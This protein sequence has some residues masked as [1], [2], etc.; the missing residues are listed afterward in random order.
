[1][2][3]DTRD[4]K[5][6][7]HEDTSKYEEQLPSAQTHNNRSSNKMTDH[8]NYMSNIRTSDCKINHTAYN[9]II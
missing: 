9:N 1:M 3:K 7:S 6:E 4:F 8:M 2:W 5:I